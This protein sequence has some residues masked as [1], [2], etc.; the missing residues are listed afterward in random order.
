MHIDEADTNTLL[1]VL[2]N[3]GIDARVIL[4]FTDD[5]INAEI[6]RRFQ[7]SEREIQARHDAEMAQTE[8][9]DEI[10]QTLQDGD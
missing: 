8:D 7:I 5:E 3:R 2:A 10:Q 1:E 4:D 6:D 9:A